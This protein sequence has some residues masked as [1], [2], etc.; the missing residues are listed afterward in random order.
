[1]VERDRLKNY[2]DVNRDINTTF[3]FILLLILKGIYKLILTFIILK[4]YRDDKYY[5]GGKGRIGCLQNWKNSWIKKS[6]N[7]IYCIIMIV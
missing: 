6:K 3:K 2:I 7:C 4:P 1:M 5:V